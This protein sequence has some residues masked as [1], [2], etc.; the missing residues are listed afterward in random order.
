MFDF[1]LN[2]DKIVVLCYEVN[3]GHYSNTIKFV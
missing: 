1:K 3:E 2:I